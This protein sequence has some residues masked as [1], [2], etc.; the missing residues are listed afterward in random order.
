VWRRL[1][2]PMAPS[3]V[4]LDLYFRRSYIDIIQ[5]RRELGAL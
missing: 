1:G 2:E 4:F 5:Q 3:H